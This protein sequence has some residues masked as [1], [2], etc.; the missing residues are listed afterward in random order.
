MP[1]KAEFLSALNEAVLEKKSNSKYS[2]NFLM[3]S[4]H[5]SHEGSDNNSVENMLDHLG[6]KPFGESID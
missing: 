3:K 4:Q 5:S 2:S 1:C 6:A